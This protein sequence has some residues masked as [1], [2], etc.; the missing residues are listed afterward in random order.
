M[1]LSRYGSAPRLLGTF[2]F[3]LT[4]VMYYLYLPVRMEDRAF[5][6]HGYR[7]PPN[8]G[9][10]RQLIAAAEHS[11]LPR[12]YRYAYLSARKGWATPDNPLN[13]PGWHADGFGTDD[14]NFVW[15]RG[16]GTRFAVQDFEAISSDHLY[17]QQQFERQ[18][19]PRCVGSRPEM[20]LYALD[21][22]CVHAT[23]LLTKGE[24][25]QYVKVSLSDHRYNLDNNSHNY[26]FEYC[27][28]LHARSEIR[29]DTSK[30]QADYA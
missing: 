23:P 30:A 21:P 5:H 18:V 4:E 27:W 26:L 15:W 7:L 12:R 17:S 22:Y 9:I 1:T 28:P 19:N 3:D 10:C 29:N 24:M 16:S 14:M 8:V 2:H 13:R 6:P 20:G 11:V 25:R